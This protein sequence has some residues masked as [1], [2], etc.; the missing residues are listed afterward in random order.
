[1]CPPPLHSA[2]EY[3]DCAGGGYVPVPFGLRSPF[4]KCPSHELSEE[5]L[6]RLRARETATLLGWAGAGGGVCGR[7]VTLGRGSDWGDQG[8][9]DRTHQ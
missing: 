9:G 3:T 5:P 7:M 2:Q 6:D 1:M 4:P 8:D